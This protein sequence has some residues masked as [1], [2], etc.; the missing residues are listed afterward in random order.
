MGSGSHSRDRAEAFAFRGVEKPII[1]A[2]E[3][4]RW[5]LLSSDR[6]CGT[7]L[8][9]IRSTER[10][11]REDGQRVPAHREHIGHLVPDR[12]ELGEAAERIPAV[13]PGQLALSGSTL[14]GTGELHS[15]PRPRDD[16]RVLLQ[17]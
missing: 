2:D 5:C 12:G 4:E 3:A 13:F 16:V 14:D 10:M 17:Q 1:K 15:G 7:E 8:R 9:C 11:A 6:E